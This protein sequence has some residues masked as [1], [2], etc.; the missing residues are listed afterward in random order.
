M[1]DSHVLLLT[2]WAPS[3]LLP[4]YAACEW[5]HRGTRW[6]R[7]HPGYFSIQIF[8][9]GGSH[10]SP[11]IFILCPRHDVA[12]NGPVDGTCAWMGWDI[13][14]CHWF[15]YGGFMMKLD[16]RASGLKGRIIWRCFATLAK[17]EFILYL[18]G[19]LWTWCVLQPLN[20]TL[21]LTFT[22]KWPF[23]A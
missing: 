10:D 8:T 20:L 4:V 14:H 23:E 21:I 9:M 2:W 12:W 15:L 11:S 1:I 19:P 16:C 6:Q 5:C 22:L 13:L 17:L 18:W 3:L 7:P